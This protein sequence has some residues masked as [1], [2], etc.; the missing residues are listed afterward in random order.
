MWHVVKLNIPDAPPSN[1]R[2][3]SLAYST[4]ASLSKPCPNQQS[5]RGGYFET[6]AMKQPELITLKP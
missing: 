3:T 4:L 2:Q 5:N 1:I 6:L